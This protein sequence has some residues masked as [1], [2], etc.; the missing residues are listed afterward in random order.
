MIYYIGYDIIEFIGLKLNSSSWLY[1][2]I[3]IESSNQII[4]NKWFH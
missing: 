3:E 4:S 1:G 2:K